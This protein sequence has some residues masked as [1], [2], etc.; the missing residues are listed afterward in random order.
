MPL[1][2]WL[3]HDEDLRAADRAP[4]WLLEGVRQMNTGTVLEYLFIRIVQWSPE[5]VSALGRIR[6]QRPYAISSDL[7]V[8][9]QFS[10]YS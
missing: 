8:F 4:L 10:V 2:Q 3:T 5:S 6:L 1:L 7:I 9:G